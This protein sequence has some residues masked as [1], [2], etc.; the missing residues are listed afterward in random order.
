MWRVHRLIMMHK[1]HA[2]LFPYY[3]LMK[4]WN[5]VLNWILIVLLWDVSRLS[6]HRPSGLGWLLECAMTLLFSFC[7]LS[8]TSGYL[9][10]MA[11]AI[12]LFITYESPKFQILIP[13]S[14]AL[15]LAPM[16]KGSWCIYLPPQYWNSRFSHL[17]FLLQCMPWINC[18]RH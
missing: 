9:D 2:T 15:C 14:R 3:W 18:I 10:I 12:C 13:V 16:K 8:E 11:S 5:W 4:M 1:S 17:P 6:S 7:H